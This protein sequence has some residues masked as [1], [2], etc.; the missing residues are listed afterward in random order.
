MKHSLESGVAFLSIEEAARLLRRKKISPVDLVDEALERIERLNPSLNAFI[1]VLREQALQAARRRER[2]LRSR[3]DRGPLH[4]IPITLK[5]NFL[6]RGI[7]TTAGSKILSNYVPSSHSAVARKLELAGAILLGKTNLHEFAYGISNENDHFGPAHN[8][9][10]PDRVTGGSSGGSAAAVAAGIGFASMGT[11][12][13]GSVRIPAA[14]CGVTGL[15]PTFGLVS[16]E[17]VI[18]LSLSADHVGPIA[19]TVTDACILLETIAE[20]YPKGAARPD[21]RKLRSRATLKCQVGW[22]KN[23]FFERI[24]PEVMR[25]IEAARKC[26]EAHGG[27]ICEAHLPRITDWVRAATTIGIAEAA[28]YHQSQGYFPARQKEY[29][30]EIAERLEMGLSVSAVDYIRALELR[31][32]AQRDMDSVFEK[33]DVILAPASPIP[34][35]RIGENEITIAGEKE[36][37]R[38]AVVRVNR[39][40]NFTGHPSISVPC[41][42]TSND[43]PVGLQMIG[44]RWG[45]A[46]LLS[47]A[48]AYEQSNQWHNRHPKL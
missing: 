45:E 39:P 4:G 43:L 16:V 36:T 19:R 17:G 47:I 2:E 7:R 10:S 34:A 9:W 37:V 31:R 18:P 30:K 32:E 20:A 38:S 27:K 28:R 44:P 24:D 15:K 12:T 46:R 3:K 29:G 11:D 33:V 22:P 42:F 1:T 40:A 6:T 41:G 26:F 5:D 25:F 13:A 14:L 35:W 23:Y 48:L 21:H 8:P